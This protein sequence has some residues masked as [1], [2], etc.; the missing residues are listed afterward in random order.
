MFD[1]QGFTSVQLAVRNQR[2]DI[3]QCLLDHCPSVSFA[4]NEKCEAG[5][6]YADFHVVHLCCESILTA[7]HVDGSEQ[8][9]NNNNSNNNSRRDSRAS[10]SVTATNRDREN[11]LKFLLSHRDIN[12]HVENSEGEN[13][14]H[15]CA[16]TNRVSLG[17]ILV[18]HGINVNHRA[19]KSW[20]SPLMV[21]ATLGHEE[22]VDFLLSLMD[23]VCMVDLNMVDHMN[24]SALHYATQSKIQRMFKNGVQISDKHERI[25]YRLA[26]CGIDLDIE[27][28]DG[29][30]ALDFISDNLGRVL[31]AVNKNPESY[32]QTLSAL[33]QNVNERGMTY[34]KQ[35]SSSVL[36]HVTEREEADCIEKAKTGSCPFATGN[37][38]LMK[39]RGITTS[40]SEKPSMPSMPTAHS[41]DM[42][43]GDI[44]QCPFFK[45]QNKE[46]DSTANRSEEAPKS[47]CPIP[48]HNEL[49]VITKAS[50]WLYVLLLIS[51]GVLGHWLG[52][53]V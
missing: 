27:S 45:N 1:D 36:A 4:L 16:K 26:Y 49:M 35:F 31:R 32:P 19:N 51:C 18:Q 25:A 42:M 46:V 14:L 24:D 13:A 6:A 28:N 43:K 15:I 38:Y 3:L 50:F 48:F 23:N 7:N 33:I 53:R 20:C 37:K 2:L 11:M 10:A 39:K 9:T 40:P 5:G 47:K 52:K 21:A 41:P 44:S 17:R 34:D 22:F 8:A 12:V 29:Y 30:R